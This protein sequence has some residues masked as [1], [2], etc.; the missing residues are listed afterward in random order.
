MYYS[1]K[2][3]YRLRLRACWRQ[4]TYPAAVEASRGGGGG[5]EG[6]SLLD[7]ELGLRCAEDRGFLFCGTVR[8]TLLFQSKYRLSALRFPSTEPAVWTY[9]SS[10]SSLLGMFCVPLHSPACAICCF[11]RSSH[12]CVDV[13]IRC[14]NWAFCWEICISFVSEFSSLGTP[15][16]K[17]CCASP[18]KVDSEGSRFYFV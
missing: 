10:F 6:M 15:N 11:P 1:T 13:I 5:E 12:S 3:L 7:V 2:E 16:G 17:L 8:T 4:Q 14:L 9:P 18:C